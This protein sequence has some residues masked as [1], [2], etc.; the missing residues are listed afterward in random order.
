VIVETPNNPVVH[1]WHCKLGSQS[2]SDIPPKVHGTGAILA[3]NH[4]GVEEWGL[5]IRTDNYTVEV[6]THLVHG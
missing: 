1:H 4:S 6:S 3:A 2:W 5:I